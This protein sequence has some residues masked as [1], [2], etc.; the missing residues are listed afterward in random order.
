MRKIT[1]VPALVLALTMPPAE[2]EH[3]DIDLRDYD[4]ELMRTLEK[5]NKY[6]E[7]DLMA[8]NLD[9]AREDALVLRYGL[10]WIER[11]F[12]A[13]GNAEDAVKIARDGL[14]LLSVAMQDA[15]RRNFDGAADQ[16]HELTRTCRSCHDIYKPLTK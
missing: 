8:G 5:T 1:M 14:A 7:P 3:K 11:Y 6:F 10:S 2:A 9:A 13:K 16:A 4:D 12:L 15:E